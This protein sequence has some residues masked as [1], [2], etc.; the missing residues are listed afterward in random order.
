MSIGTAFHPRTAPLNRK[1]QWREWAGYLAA[2]AYADHLDIEYNAIRE[3]AALIDVTPLYKYLVSGPDAV[4]LIDRI[5]TRDASKLQVGQIYYTC[6][7]D[8]DGKVIDDG[9]VG[10]LDESTYRWTAA[11]PSD[12][13]STRLNSSH[14]TISYAVFCLKKKNKK[15]STPILTKSKNRSTKKTIKQANG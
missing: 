2:S 4:R 12:R 7:C 8:E 13:K 5:I 9:T 15:N 10:R 6:W 11:D 3:A 14:I 1:M